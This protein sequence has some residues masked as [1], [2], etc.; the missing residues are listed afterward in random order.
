[1]SNRETVK[2]F[3]R[4][5]GFPLFRFADAATETDIQSLITRLALPGY[6]LA[7]YI[8]VRPDP[9]SPSPRLLSN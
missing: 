2:S 9:A 3:P 4:I 1:M 5:L 7:V 6:S 8:S